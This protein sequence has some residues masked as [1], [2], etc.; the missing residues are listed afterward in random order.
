MSPILPEQDRILTLQDHQQVL[1]PPQKHVLQMQ[2]ADITCYEFP[3]SGLEIII[4]CVAIGD[5]NTTV[6]RMFFFVPE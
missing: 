5:I 2:V 6:P 4:P 3:L 1:I